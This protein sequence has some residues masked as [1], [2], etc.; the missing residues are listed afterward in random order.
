MSESGQK[1]QFD[2][3]PMTSGVRPEADSTQPSLCIN[4]FCQS[5]PSKPSDSLSR[6]EVARNSI[7]LSRFVGLG[8]HDRSRVTNGNSIGADVPA[9]GWPLYPRYF[10]KRDSA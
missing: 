4:C 6:D 9:C 5:S 7:R 3:L 2:C 10:T 8:V 1:R